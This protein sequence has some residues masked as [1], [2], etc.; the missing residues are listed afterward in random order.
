[1]A[2]LRRA[3]KRT[4]SRGLSLDKLSFGRLRRERIKPLRVYLA[5]QNGRP[6]EEAIR[7]GTRAT[8]DFEGFALPDDQAFKERFKQALI[9][10][11]PDSYKPDDRVMSCFDGPLPLTAPVQLFFDSNLTAQPTNVGAIDASQDPWEFYDIAFQLPYH[12]ISTGLLNFPQYSDRCY[13]PSL[14]GSVSGIGVPITGQAQQAYATD[15]ETCFRRRAITI[16]VFDHKSSDKRR[17]GVTKGKTDNTE[18]DGR[19]WTALII[20]PVA[21]PSTDL[22][23]PLERLLD[24]AFL[25][26]QL[27]NSE[28]NVFKESD[29]GWH[30]PQNA[31]YFQTRLVELALRRTAETWQKNVDFTQRMQDIL[32]DESK[33]E[34]GIYMR[35]RNARLGRKVDELGNWLDEFDDPTVPDPIVPQQ[36][37]DMNIDDVA[38]HIQNDCDRHLHLLEDL[39]DVYWFRMETSQ[40]KLQKQIQKMDT[41]RALVTDLSQTRAT[42]YANQLGNH[43]K[44]LTWVSVVFIPLGFILGL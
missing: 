34:D 41:L 15:N 1:M 12:V 7:T 11:T 6:L 17:R 36:Y 37:R 29:M 24:E 20:D 27:P 25:N 33:G 39:C 13:L 8:K 5:R 4:G 44:Y 18:S 35:F 21:Q 32:G 10:C 3:E 26:H 16:C 38:G 2:S 28:R 30:Y 42:L 14:Q 23:Y 22:E 19:S 43:V 9:I 31:D 40:S